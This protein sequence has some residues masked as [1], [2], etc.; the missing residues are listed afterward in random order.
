MQEHKGVVSLEL[1][2]IEYDATDRKLIAALSHNARFTPTFLGKLVNLSKDGVRYRL[3]KLYKN[4]TILANIPVVSP[5][6]LG[7]GLY[8]VVFDIKEPDIE[9]EK[10]LM[11]QLAA[12]QHT[13][14]VGHSIGKWNLAVF[15][16][17]KP[18][19]KQA[20]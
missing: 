16:I 3:E 13:I 8:A 2:G 19:E 6:A 10:K 14:W 18:K 5:Y 1:P 17:A 4:H 7:Y 20:V 9:E 12:H 15:F 11:V